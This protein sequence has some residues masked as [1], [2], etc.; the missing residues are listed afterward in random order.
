MKNEFTVLAVGQ[1]FPTP[2]PPQDTVVAQISGTTLD[3]VIQVNR[4]TASEKRALKE[5]TI[6]RAWQV[7]NVCGLVAKVGTMP[8][9]D[10]SI[11]ACLQPEEA[12][13]FIAKGGNAL[14]YYV[15]DRGVIQKIGLFGLHLSGVE[16]LKAT[17]RK[18]LEVGIEGSAW[19]SALQKVYRRFSSDSLANLSLAHDARKAEPTPQEVHGSES[20]AENT[21]TST[22]NIVKLAQLEAFAVV[23]KKY[24]SPLPS[25]LEPFY[26]YM[27]DGGHSII[28]VVSDTLDLPEPHMSLCPVPV[29]TVMRLGWTV[30]DGF[31]WCNVPYSSFLGVLAPEEDREY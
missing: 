13:L 26:S 10:A 22:S 7:G 20:T 31:V 2:L 6:V 1:R 12:A 4:M 3:L 11:N 16:L 19:D 28:A 8:W 5:R 24:P 14:N 9:M 27:A 17:F 30:R 25:D 18:Q 29:K 15:L 21:S 23:G